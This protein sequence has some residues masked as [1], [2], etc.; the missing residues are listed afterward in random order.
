MWSR[1]NIRLVHTVYGFVRVVR[2]RSNYLFFTLFHH[3]VVQT[4]RRKTKVFKRSALNCCLFDRTSDYCFVRFVR[5]L[6]KEK[7]ICPRAS[8]AKC[9]NPITIILCASREHHI[10]N[11]AQRATD[12]ITFMQIVS[13]LYIYNTISSI[14]ASCN[15]K[16]AYAFTWT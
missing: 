5:L 3:R 15:N 16:H 1:L 13:N 14:P 2:G 7:K 11:Y 6:L 9:A 10:N 12:S 8:I 4:A